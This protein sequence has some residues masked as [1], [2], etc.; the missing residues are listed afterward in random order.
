MPLVE[1]R[2]QTH[3][4]VVDEAS[5]RETGIACDREPPTEGEER[6]YAAEVA[7]R[8]RRAWH[9]RQCWV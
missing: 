2:K 1:R 5:A 9:G 4:E 7:W 8:R 3:V 6:F